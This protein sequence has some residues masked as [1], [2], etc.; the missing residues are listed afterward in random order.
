MKINF[1]GRLAFVASGLS[2]LIYL[3]KLSMAVGKSSDQA[4]LLLAGVDMLHGNWQL[5]GWSM[6]ADDYWTS[7]VIFGGV[8]TGIRWLFGRPEVSP[9]TLV[10]QPAMNWMLLAMTAVFLAQRENV[11]TPPRWAAGLIVFASLGVPVMRPGAA[12]TLVLLSGIHI[13]TIFYTLLAVALGQQVL[14]RERWRIPLAGM[15]AFLVLGVVGDPLMLFICIVPI[16]IVASVRPSRRMLIIGVAAVFSTVSARVILAAN[17]WT[18]GFTVAE[19]PLEFAR[20]DDLGRNA[21]VVLHG[22]MSV[23]S[24]DF[25][26]RSIAGAIP[27]LLHVPLLVFAGVFVGLAVARLI[28]GQTFRFLGDCD[29]ITASL[30][31]GAALDI[32]ALLFSK[33]VEYENGSFATARY[34]FP[35]WVFGSI[36]LARHAGRFRVVTWMSAAALLS[37]LVYNHGH[38]RPTAAPSLNSN[39]YALLTA[40]QAQPIRAGFAGYWQAALMQVASGNRLRVEA[41]IADDRGR[42]VRLQNAS[43]VFSFRDITSH[44]FFVVVWNQPLYFDAPAVIRSFGPPDHTQV[45]SDYTVMFYHGRT[46]G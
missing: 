34:L 22:L 18:G 45:V 5:R 37:A 38:T 27:D 1:A 12:T 2:L 21:G 4:N 13:L 17:V 6:V 24:A 3:Q 9:I 46:S 33:R 42:L 39:E 32:I 26:G 40:L 23:F 19:L 10:W 36:L 20:F 41:C 14:V 43:K 11:N 28:F 25:T 30:A 29:F 44:D 7:D 16:L 31:I 8:L 35:A 15:I